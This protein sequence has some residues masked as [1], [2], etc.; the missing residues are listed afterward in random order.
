VKWTAAVIGVAFFACS[1]TSEA[2]SLSQPRP[3]D[4]HI[5]RVVQTLMGREHLSRRPLDDEISRRMLQSFLRSLDPM[6]LF[7]YQS[8]VDE[9]EQ[10]RDDLDD[11]LKK[12]DVSFAYTVFQQ[13][14]QR[15]DERMELV[16]EL[17]DE[18]HDFAVKEEML[19][20]PKA[21]SYA[22][23]ETQARER[24]RKRIKYDLLVL[25]R[26]KTEG[27]QAKEKLS[28]RYAVFARR[29]HRTGADELLEMYL[30]AMTTGFDPHSAYLSPDSLENHRI[31]TRR[32]LE[33]IGAAM[34]LTDGELVVA[35]IIPGA[36][37]DKH[38]KLRPEDRIVSVG[39]GRDGEMV[40]VRGMKLADIV[41][42]IRGRSGTMIR[43]GVIPA[44]RGETKTYE[45]IRGGISLTDD[46]V[47]SQIIEA[48]GKSGDATRKIGII[49]S[50][51][52]YMD[53]EGTRKEQADLDGA[54]RDVTRILNEFTDKHVDA[55][56]LDL[57]NSRGENLAQ[58][59]A[60]TGL[61]IEHG[62]IVQAKDSGGQV[63]RYDDSESGAIWTGPLVVITNKF[64]TG[65]GEILAAAVQ[66]YR[67]G[68]VVGDSNTNGKGTF[69][70][71]LD[72][73]D[74]LFRI[75]NP[76]RL[77]ALKVT[78]TQV[79]RPSGDSIQQRG[80]SA[81]I[82]LPSLTGHM[83]VSESSLEN[84][85]PFDQVPA[86]SYTPSALVNEDILA[87]LRTASRS[88]CDESED[89]AKLRRAIERYKQQKARKSVPLNEQDFLNQLGQ[90]DDE[91]AAPEV[92]TDVASAS[93]DFYF[94][95]V[96]AITLDYLNTL[97]AD[98]EGS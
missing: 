46:D 10:R 75:P 3:Q 54:A 93:E 64:T 87:A 53:A 89:F 58:A 31:E 50:P 15:V 45:I 36:A 68:L 32:K 76:P 94:K 1:Q 80:A 5:A 70:H 35:K 12:G 98:K 28:R 14:L 56:I 77:G 81:D 33:G 27:E 24:W 21:V 78:M 62:P 16:G 41:R 91:T 11:M 92:S 43:L 49:S 4:R 9:F 60:V 69:Q 39:Q 90:P 13:F 63:Q 47:R 23:D 25:K 22:V 2:Q 71:V 55:V 57:R 38:G 42:L 82:V 86:E 26:D 79:Y 65:A 66:D 6:K 61:F 51:S 96:I 84:A 17:I 19:T 34:R 85:M 83:D 37:A 29:P 67:R 8:D 72:L 95:E 44:G 20:S 74:Q 73:G 97:K 30:T 18:E 40:N 48:G 88:R 7:F 52:F 59:L